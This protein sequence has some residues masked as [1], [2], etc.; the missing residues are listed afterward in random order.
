MKTIVIAPHPD[1][2][3]LG[4]G[5]SLLRRRQQGSEIG[6]VLVTEIAKE[7]GYSS[8][9]VAQRFEEIEKVREGLGVRSEHLYTLGFPTSELDVVPMKSLVSAI[10]QVFADFGPTEVFLPFSGDAHSDHR[11]VHEAGTACVKWF[12]APSI[13]R[14]LMYETPSET[15]ISLNRQSQAFRPN[16]YVDVSE[17]F[18]TKLELISNYYSELGAFP[19][20]RSLDSLRA[21]AMKRG[22]E[23]GF[24]L[25]EAFELILERG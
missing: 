15:D 21:L 16:S 14:V 17:V 3:L 10:A 11:R 25:A 2:E 13:E 5:G 24:Q 9:Q 18:D 12:R 19:F 20:P 7:K 8:A 1:D 22:V 6:W 23:S 4:C